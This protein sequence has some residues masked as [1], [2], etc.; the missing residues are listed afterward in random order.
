MEETAGENQ[1]FGEDRYYNSVFFID[2][3]RG[4]VVGEYAGSYSSNKVGPKATASL[5]FIEK[6]EY[7]Y[8]LLFRSVKGF[9]RAVP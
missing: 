3:R 6:G 1:G 5:C 4:W 9:G 8:E 2:E 7:T